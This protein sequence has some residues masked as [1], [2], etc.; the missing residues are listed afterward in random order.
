[1]KHIA[2]LTI[3]LIV[4]VLALA[5]LATADVP[6][7]INYQGRL[8]DSGENPLTGSYNVLFSIYD[9]ENHGNLLWQEQHSDLNGNPVDVQNGLFD[10]I[11]GENT[12]IPDSVF[13]G[14][15]RWLAIKVGADPELTP[16]TRL[17][18][19]AYSHRVSTVSANEI[20]DEPG[21]AQ[22]RTSNVVVTGATTMIDVVTVTIDIPAPGYVVLEASAEAR[23]YNTF[24]PNCMACQIDKTA[25]GSEDYDY[26]Y[27]VGFTTPPNTASMWFPVSMRRTYYE[28]SGG[29]Y[30]YRFEALDETNEGSKSMRNS[31]ITAT[32]TPTSYGTVT[33]VVSPS[34]A[35][36][37]ENAVPITA[38][39]NGL[40]EAPTGEISYLVDLRELEQKAA[41][42]KAE[43]EKVQREIDEAET[44]K[45]EARFK[46]RIE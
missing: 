38:G 29:S 12:A 30:T 5:S 36:Q 1:M 31:V 25:G 9:Q 20:L 23:L 27:F 7:M 24:S 18:S 28:S 40:E 26:C 45:Q 34:E 46:E 44:R 41:R 37:F 42:L 14:S 21:I 33:A 35:A 8:T 19:V 16:R 43:L 4:A 2:Q 17:V 39:A 3:T 6:H 13:D 15:V 32:Y 11:L 22:G 10:V